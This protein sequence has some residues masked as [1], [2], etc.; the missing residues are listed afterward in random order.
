MIKTKQQNTKHEIEP[1][2]LT[3]LPALSNLDVL[4][5]KMCRSL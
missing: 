5:A 1:H 4:V 2:H 3:S